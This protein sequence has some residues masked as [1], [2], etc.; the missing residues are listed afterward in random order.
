MKKFYSSFPIYYEEL[1]YLTFEH[2]KLLVNISDSVEKYFY[3]RIALFCNSTVYELKDIINE[4]VYYF[5]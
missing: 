1:N 5:I 2:Y 3:F 4:E